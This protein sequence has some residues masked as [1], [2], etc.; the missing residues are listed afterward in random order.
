MAPTVAKLS[1]AAFAQTQLS[2]L[3]AEQ[4][5]E[6]AETTLLLSESS[7]TT[8]A[9][10]GLAILNLISLSQRTG[11]GGKS[12]VELGLDP[13]V[14]S[15]EKGGSDLPEHG[16]RTGDIVRVSEPP[17]GGA[18]K[19]EKSEMKGKGVEG[20]VTRVGDRAVWVALGKAYADDDEDDV[21]IGKLWLYV[22]NHRATW[23]DEALIRLY[24]AS[25]WLMMLLTKGEMTLCAC[26]ISASGQC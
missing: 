5:A 11:L 24:A 23:N 9:R 10:A 26:S 7:P 3:K 8:L 6:V 21:P 1:P 17:S 12:V 18:K 13:A 20:V 15:A 16:V 4:S 25:R 14:A 2:L 19:K 22:C